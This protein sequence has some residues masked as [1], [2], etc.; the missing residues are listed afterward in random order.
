MVNHKKNIMKNFFTLSFI[1][2][3]LWSCNPSFTPTNYTST[4]FHNRE[5][6]VIPFEVH[7]SV[8]ELPKGVTIAMIEK[9]EQRK[10]II[11][12]RD[13]YR[14]LLRELAKSSRKVKLQDPNKT[15]RIFKKYGMDHERIFKTPKKRLARILGVDAVLFGNVYQSKQKLDVNH[16][17]LLRMGGINNKISTVLYVYEKRRGRIEWKY[18]RSQSGFPSDVAPDVV[19]GLLRK[20]A[21]NFPM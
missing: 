13:M 7:T 8:K 10:A 20:A 16:E 1:S 17:E 12:Q 15:N 2:I 6:A 11:M 4:R 14:Y 3:F 21:R 5:I 18:D 19:K 9:A